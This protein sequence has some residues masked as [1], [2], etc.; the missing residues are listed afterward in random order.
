MPDDYKTEVWNDTPVD[1]GVSQRAVL[2]NGDCWVAIP[3]GPGIRPRLLRRDP[4]SEWQTPV[5]REEWA[6]F[7]CIENDS[8]VSGTST[9]TLGLL[10][11]DLVGE[12]ALPDEDLPHL[13]ILRRHRRQEDD[14]VA[15]IQ[16]VS[17]ETGLDLAMFAAETC[18][19]DL[20]GYQIPASRFEDDAS[21]TLM[22]D[23]SLSGDTDG[24]LRALRRCGRGDAIDAIRRPNSQAAARRAQRRIGLDE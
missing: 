3:P 4:A 18:I 21:D 2:I 8:R 5:L 7:S 10:D 15:W 20:D 22:C 16:S 13:S 9:W 24:L 17:E 23:L 14:V 11:D 1:D 12:L 6:S 19:G